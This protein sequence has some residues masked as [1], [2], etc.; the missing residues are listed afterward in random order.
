MRV[1]FHVSSRINHFQ[2]IGPKVTVS[3]PPKQH[4]MS[5]HIVNCHVLN[6]LDYPLFVIFNGTLG[7]LIILK[8]VPS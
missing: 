4:L 1:G 5:T 2:Y 3:L 7:S 6:E 8:S